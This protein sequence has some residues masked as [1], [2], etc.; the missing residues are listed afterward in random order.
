[1][2]FRDFV[3]ACFKGIAVL[4]EF[5][6]EAL[7]IAEDHV[8]IFLGFPPRYWISQVVQHLKGNSGPRHISGIPRC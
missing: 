5:E 4:N 1:V 6:I 8:H 2:I 7:E 3:E